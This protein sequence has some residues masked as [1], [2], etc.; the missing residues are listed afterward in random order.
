MYETSMFMKYL[1]K[2]F[3]TSGEQMYFQNEPNYRIFISEY[4]HFIMGSG[5]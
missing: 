1:A 3:Y 2:P 4:C 5:Q